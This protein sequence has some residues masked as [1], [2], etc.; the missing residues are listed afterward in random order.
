MR[1]LLDPGDAPA[2]RADLAVDDRTR[3]GGPE[4]P[5]AGALLAVRSG[6]VLIFELLFVVCGGLRG[7]QRSGNPECRE[8]DGGHALQREAAGDRLLCHAEALRVL[9]SGA[10]RTAGF[11]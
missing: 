6:L 8:R 3:R 4:Q 9:E 5:A 10:C 7:R 2:V 1:L 11:S